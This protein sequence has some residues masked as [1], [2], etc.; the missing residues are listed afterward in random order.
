MRKLARGSIGVGEGRGR[1]LRGEGVLGGGN[2]V[3]GG[4]P[5]R[6][7]GRGSSVWGGTERGGAGTRGGEAKWGGEGCRGELGSGGR[8]RTT[9]ARARRVVA[10][11]PS[12]IDGQ[13]SGAGRRSGRRSA[14]AA[15][16][17]MVLKAGRGRVPWRARLSRWWHRGAP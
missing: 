17:G 1:G 3:G 4:V 10:C 8:S 16:A 13:L 9:S 12:G 2:S 6:G 15:A 11:S 14:V 7:E 5:R